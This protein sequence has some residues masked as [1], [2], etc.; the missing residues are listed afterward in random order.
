MTA[1]VDT[2]FLLALIDRG[3]AF[4]T[5]C[6]TALIGEPN[7]LIPSVVL[8]ELAY[9]VIRNVGYRPIAEF[10]RSVAK[11][12]PPLIFAESG[13]FARAGDILEQYADS[14]VDFVDCAIVAMAERLNITRILT[15]DQRHFRIL[16]PEHISAF[17][18]LP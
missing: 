5:L 11:G 12:D 1:L 15:V 4:H 2:G 16:R 18:I 17:E 7:P 14:K 10:L 6:G 8:P 9:M 3:D 13:D